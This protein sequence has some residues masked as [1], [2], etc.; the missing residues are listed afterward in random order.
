MTSIIILSIL[1][2][3]A[4]ACSLPGVFLVLRRMSLIGDAI[5]HSVLPGIVIA[6]LIIGTLESPLFFVLA[7]V[8]AVLMTWFVQLITDNVKISRESVIG[9]VFTFLFSLGVVMLV[10]FANDVHLDQDAVLFGQVE[11]S[12]FNK[13]VVNGLDLGPRSLW[14]MGS[15]FLLN[16]LVLGLFAKEMKVST[17]DPGFAKSVGVPVRFMH[18]LLTTLTAISVV[19]A[20]EVTG[21]ILVVALLVIPPL[22]AYVIAK[23]LSG[24]FIL[25]FIYAITASV[26]GFTLAALFDVSIA[27]T[28]AFIAGVLLILT[29]L[30]RRFFRP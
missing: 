8:F 11:F 4:L 26:S 13:L 23:T 7:V 24:M 2:L 1:I 14:I 17:F 27:G 5:S 19:A 21:P 3:T 29:V 28:T 16:L 25:S 15:V 22:S 20:F 12:A 18:Y 9:I 6:F 30:L 10:Q